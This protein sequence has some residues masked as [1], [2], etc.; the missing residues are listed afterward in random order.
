MSRKEYETKLMQVRQ[1]VRDLLV[2]TVKKP[3]VEL[4]QYRRL[5]VRI[6]V[7]NE[8]LKESRQTPVPGFGRKWNHN[9]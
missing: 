5:K 8:L 9:E 1:S 3:T 2:Q 7:C 4:A 6:E